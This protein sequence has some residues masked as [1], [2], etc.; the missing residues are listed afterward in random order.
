MEVLNETPF[1]SFLPELWQWSVA[2]LLGLWA[3]WTTH[4][5]H[6]TSGAYLAFRIFHDLTSSWPHCAII[7]IRWFPPTSQVGT[8]NMPSLILAWVFVLALPLLGMS[9]PCNPSRPSSNVSSS[10]SQFLILQW[11]RISSSLVLL[12]LQSTPSSLPCIVLTC[13]QAWHDCELQTAEGVSD[14]N[15]YPTQ[16]LA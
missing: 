6:V 8:P 9:F 16:C 12:P 10:L 5:R 3:G 7:N 4:G 15:A 1:G 14:L 13:L 2:T 11:E